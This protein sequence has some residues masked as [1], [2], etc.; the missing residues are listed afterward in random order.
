MRGT[1]TSVYT[2]YLRSKTKVLNMKMSGPHIHRQ[3]CR[4]LLAYV[5]S[6]IIVDLCPQEVPF[7]VETPHMRQNMIICR[8]FFPNLR[9]RPAL[10]RVSWCSRLSHLPRDKRDHASGNYRD[11]P[12]SQPEPSG[13]GGACVE[14]DGDRG[15]K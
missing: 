15:E 14:V 1:F 4:R 3:S 6:D 7:S 10:Q 11:W 13:K 8:K 2:I 9:R 12:S 5:T